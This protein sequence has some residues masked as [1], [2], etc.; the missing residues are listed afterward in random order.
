MKRRSNSPRQTNR[1]PKP[2]R[3]TDAMTRKI[4]SE[5]K[6]VAL[7]GASNKKHRDSY[8][9]MGLLLDHGYDVYP[10][11]PN[12]AKL[13]ETIHG[14][15]VYSSLNELVCPQP[16]A[17]ASACACACAYE[18]GGVQIDMVDI[19]RNSH[20]AGI[21]VDEAIAIGAKS[22][23]LQEGVVN[24]AAAQRAV[25][26]GLNVA[27]DVC[28]YHE[29]PRLGIAGP[30]VDI[31]RDDSGNKGCIGDSHSDHNI[32]GAENENGEEIHTNSKTKWKRKRKCPGP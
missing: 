24:Q 17:S 9:I 7:V 13:G 18:T 2:F 16:S 10:V 31:S 23:W 19:F 14:R 26:A 6:T 20:D 5:S 15:T 30:I 1:K 22:V 25:Q 21:T 4:L 3:N 12:V 27:M 11:N 29:L 32:D 28:P 8:E